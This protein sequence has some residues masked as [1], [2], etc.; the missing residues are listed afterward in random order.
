MV[1]FRDH[2][3]DNL[4]LILKKVSLVK[5]VVPLLANIRTYNWSLP[6]T[7]EYLILPS[8]DEMSS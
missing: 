3:Q 7:P 8:L 4:V 2:F 5:I 1:Y 6:M